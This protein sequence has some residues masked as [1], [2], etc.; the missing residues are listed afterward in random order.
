MAPEVLE[1]ASDERS[2]V[3]SLGC[4]ALEMVT[5]SFIDSTD[6]AGKLFE[7]KHSDDALDVIMQQV[8]TVR[9]TAS[10]TML[11]IVS[12]RDFKSPYLLNLYNLNRITE[13]LPLHIWFF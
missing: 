13:Q 12:G 7:V 6:M 10:N 11:H 8:A 4:I 2:D 3:W 1:R 9:R 5:C